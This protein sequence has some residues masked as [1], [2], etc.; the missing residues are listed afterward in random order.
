MEIQRDRESPGGP[1]A[2]TPHP[3]AGDSGLIPSRETKIPKAMPQGQRNSPA[4]QTSNKNKKPQCDIT[5]EIR[6]VSSRPKPHRYIGGCI[7]RIYFK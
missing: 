2:R 1:E 6:Q 5:L 3:T 4:K 7:Q